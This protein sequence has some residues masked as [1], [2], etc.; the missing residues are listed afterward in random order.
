MIYSL[1]GFGLK[2]CKHFSVS[3]FVFEVTTILSYFKDR[4]SFGLLLFYVSV[5]SVS[6]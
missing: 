5:G 2:F 4:E 6:I 3:K 1:R